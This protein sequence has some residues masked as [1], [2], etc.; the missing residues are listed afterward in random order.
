MGDSGFKFKNEVKSSAY[1]AYI[2]LDNIEKSYICDVVLAERGNHLRQ[3]VQNN[4]YNAGYKAVQREGAVL[5]HSGHKGVM[6]SDVDDDSVILSLVL[7]QEYFEGVED[8]I[9]IAKTPVNLVID[10]LMDAARDLEKVLD[11]S[12][13]AADL[14]AILECFGDARLKFLESSLP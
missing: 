13:L 3:R 7:P 4:L 14:T 10:I 12:G 1:A 2:E 6:V 9:D 11:K 5:Y 8:K